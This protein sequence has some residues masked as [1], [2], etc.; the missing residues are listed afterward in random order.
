MGAFRLNLRKL[1][2][3]YSERGQR[4]GTG[5]LLPFLSGD[6]T[7]SSSTRHVNKWGDCVGE[8]KIVGGNTR[9]F[10]LQAGQS[11]LQ[12]QATVIGTFQGNWSYALGIN[13][14]RDVVGKAQN[15]VGGYRAFLYTAAGVLR[16]LNTVSGSTSWVLSDAMAINNF[17]VIVGNGSLSGYSR[18]Y[19]LIPTP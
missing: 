3:G 18:G 1:G 16:D 11:Q 5:E 9:G 10:L 19:L 4:Q 7:H 17:G 13:D 12:G 6:P 15:A 14:R 2:V 8:S